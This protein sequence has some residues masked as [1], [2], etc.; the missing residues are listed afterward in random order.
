MSKN[1]YL[2]IRNKATVIVPQ[3]R[4]VTKKKMHVLFFKNEIEI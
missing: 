4:L 1:L 3:L 2:N